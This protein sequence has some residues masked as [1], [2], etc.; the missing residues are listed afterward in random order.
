[1]SIIN[2]FLC[3]INYGKAIKYLKKIFNK[4]STFYDIIAWSEV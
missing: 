4:I 2:T 1:M 3:V